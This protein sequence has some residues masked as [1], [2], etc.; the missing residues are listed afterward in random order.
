[1]TIEFDNVLH[2]QYCYCGDIYYQPIEIYGDDLDATDKT[3]EMMTNS[4]ESWSLCDGAPPLQGHSI[5]S[6]G[7]K[8]QCNSEIDFDRQVMK[9]NCR[10]AYQGLLDNCD[11]IGVTVAEEQA[12]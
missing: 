11:D 1:M 4:T 6:F 3:I 9:Q 8:K 5:L 12:A 2:A 10:L 7:S